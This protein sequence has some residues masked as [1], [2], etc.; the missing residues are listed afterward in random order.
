MDLNEVQAQRHCKQD[1][2]RLSWQKSR[3]TAIV[4][5]NTF[6][7]SLRLCQRRCQ[8]GKAINAFLSGP[9]SPQL[10]TCLAT[11]TS[12]VTS[13]AT[14]N[15]MTTTSVSSVCPIQWIIRPTV[16]ADLSTA[17]SAAPSDASIKKQGSTIQTGMDRYINI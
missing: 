2:R 14:V 5:P 17:T 10:S 4:S 1:E 7:R 8:A 16:L 12:T 3:F 6:Q 11:V 13:L 15:A 9:A